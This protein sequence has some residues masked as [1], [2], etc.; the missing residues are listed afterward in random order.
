MSESEIEVSGQSAAAD[1]ETAVREALSLLGRALAA[2]GGAPFHL[3]SMQWLTTD[4]AAFDPKRHVVDLAYREV[5]GG[6]R[7]PVTV[8]KSNQPGLVVQARAQL[9]SQAS[10]EPIWHGYALPELAREYSP[11]GQVPNM[12]ALFEQW[13]KDGLAFC[14]GRA[15]LDIAYGA[16]PYE[17]LDLFRPA[18]AVAA[19]PLWIF[20][21]GGY[22]QASDKYQHAQFAGGMLQA[23][24]AVANLNYGLCPDVPLEG[25]VGQ[26]RAALKFLFTN[27]KELGFDPASV[28][29]AGHSAGG[30]LAGMVASD[31]TMPPIKSALLLSGLFDLTPLALL[32]V[33]KLTSVTTP[34]AIERLSPMK[35]KVRPGV[36]VGIGVGGLESDEFK[37][38]SVELARVWNAPP[39]LVIE[40]ENHFSL[41]DGLIEGRLLDFALETAGGRRSH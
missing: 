10:T 3:T 40:G 11:R 18:N 31:G 38:Q 19:P 35:N 33:G 21:H 37:W 41:L 15:G 9:S 24:Y 6:F 29:V 1:P 4:P 2:R 22:W 8:A 12:D 7:P 27:S 36:K 39:P 20:I 28:H 14:A 34:Q 23:G 13:S 5:L 25:V 30:H 17:K 32:P 26:I 16:S